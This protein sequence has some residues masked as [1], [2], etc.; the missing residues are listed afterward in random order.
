MSLV[1]SSLVDGSQETP[2]YPDFY[3]IYNALADTN[4]FPLLD[5]QGTVVRPNLDLD[6]DGLP[7]DWE[8][9]YFGSLGAGATNSSDGDGVSN[10]AK[11]VA[12]VDPTNPAT[13]L[14]ILSV[15]D[16][17][18]GVEIHFTF[19]PD[20]QYKI[21]WSDDLKNWQTAANPTLVDTSDWLSKTGTNLVYPAPVYAIWR[22]T[23]PSG[24]QRFYK[25]GVQ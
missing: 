20:R 11:Y 2:N 5:I 24:Q 10:L 22:Y 17:T 7:D 18:N 19:A 9:F 8:Q 13:D 1:A 21:L 3:T 12:G 15:N 14:Q 16:S 25:I 23:N 4:Q 6:R